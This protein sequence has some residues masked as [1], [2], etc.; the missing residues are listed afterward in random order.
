MAWVQDNCIVK[1]E[2][3]FLLM[4]KLYMKFRIKKILIVEK[5]KNLLHHHLLNPDLIKILF[6]LLNSGLPTGPLYPLLLGHYPLLHHQVI[7]TKNKAVITRRVI[8]HG[9]INI[10]TLIQKILVIGE[11]GQ[12][13]MSW[14]RVLNL[15]QI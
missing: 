5:I 2:I 10:K 15:N 11:Q 8:N 3:I 14:I 1:E 9:I 7:I 6:P 4:K 13:K 12:S